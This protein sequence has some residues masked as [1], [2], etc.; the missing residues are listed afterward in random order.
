MLNKIQFA[1]NEID[2]NFAQTRSKF[3]ISGLKMA[4]AFALQVPQ[5]S[6]FAQPRILFRCPRNNLLYLYENVDPVEEKI[7]HLSRHSYEGQEV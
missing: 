7:G 2:L 3:S 1:K 5:N 6:S 4:L